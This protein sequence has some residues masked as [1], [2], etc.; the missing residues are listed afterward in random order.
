[1]KESE[2]DKNR[3]DGSVE[4]SDLFDSAMDRTPRT[5]AEAKTT[6]REGV[7]VVEAAFARKLEREN[8]KLRIALKRIVDAGGI[9]PEDMFD[10]ARDLLS[11]KRLIIT[12]EGKSYVAKH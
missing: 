8:Q 3:R 4:S 10:D 11:N 12:K 1:M 2:N 5:D 9:G 6:P 7:A